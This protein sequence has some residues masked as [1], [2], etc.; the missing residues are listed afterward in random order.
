MELHWSSRT[1]VDSHSPPFWLNLCLSRCY[2]A[3]ARA[4]ADAVVDISAIISTYQAVGISLTRPSRVSHFAAA[5]TSPTVVDRHSARGANVPK[6]PTFKTASAEPS[7]AQPAQPSI[8]SSASPV[9]TH[10]VQP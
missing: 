5:E 9:L 3:T 6:L 8:L 10:V 7:A 1:I 4:E 2:T